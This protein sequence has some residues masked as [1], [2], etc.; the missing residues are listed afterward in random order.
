MSSV[1]LTYSKLITTTVANQ[2]VNLADSGTLGH[3]VQCP[4]SV[5]DLNRFFIW[6]RPAGVQAPVGHFAAHEDTP[7]SSFSYILANTLSKYYTD[8]D[9]VSNGLNFGS[10]ILD[11]NLDPSIRQDGQISANDLIMA[12]VIYKLYG[13]SASPTQ[14]IIYNLQDAYGMLTNSTLISSIET[15]LRTEEAS[16]NA[17][18]V[19]EMFQDL[20]SQD[21]TRFFDAA[22]KQI[23]GLFEVNTATPSTGP[24]N[25]VENDRIELNV[26]FTFSNAVTLA[27]SP[28]AASVATTISAG[29]TFK[30]RLQLLATNT[31][32]AASALVT[33]AAEAKA[34]E[35]LRQA[36]EQQEAA[37][38]AAAAVAAA[39]QAEA[40]AAKQ[41][42]ALQATYTAAIT[43]NAE[44]QKAVLSAQ[45]AVQAAQA[46]LAAATISGNQANIQQQNAA[47]VVAQ[48]VLNN[49]Q[50]IAIQA[51][52]DLQNAANAVA[53]ATATVNATQTA[54]A[55][56]AAQAAAANAKKAKGALDLELASAESLQ[57][58]IAAAIAASDPFTQ[59]LEQEKEAILDPQNLVT[60]M[61]KAN[62]AT[63]TRQAAFNTM[64]QTFAKQTEQLNTYTTLTDTMNSAIAMGS[65]V[66]Q[67]QLVNSMV[68]GASNLVN[69]AMITSGS[70]ASTLVASYSAEINAIQR[71]T[72][73]S[74]NAAS[75]ASVVAI[76]NTNS[77]NKSLT[78][79]TTAYV[80]A[81]TVNANAAAAA[82]DAQT[83][84]NNRVANGA[85]MSE[86]QTRMKALLDANATYAATT[87]TLYGNQA[88][89]TLAT[90]AYQA[91]STIA[92]NAKA[93]IS[94]VAASNLFALS[95][96]K[97]SVS[98][99]SSYQANVMYNA[100]LN[101]LATEVNTGLVKLTQ[102]NSDVAIAKAN[103]SLAQLKINNALARGQSVLELTVLNDI[104]AKANDS[105][106]QALLIQTTAQAA[107]DRKTEN[108]K[109]S[110]VQLL[111][112][113]ATA[114]FNA[115]IT[116]Q[117]IATDSIN[118][119]ST[120]V[121]YATQDPVAFPPI[122]GIP[123]ADVYSTQ[124]GVWQTYLGNFQTLSGS[125]LT[126]FNKDL[127]SASTLMAANPAISTSIGSLS[128]YYIASS[129]S[130]HLAFQV[131][132]LSTFFT[133]FSTVG[134]DAS[135]DLA[136]YSSQYS[137]ASA[138]AAA[139]YSSNLAA[140]LASQT[141]K[142]VSSIGQTI[143]LAAEAQQLAQISTATVNS[144]INEY[145]ASVSTLSMI[146]L[147]YDQASVAATVAGQALSNA[148]ITTSQGRMI[149]YQRR[150]AD[151][152]AA[153]SALANE[154]NGASQTVSSLVMSLGVGSAST[155]T[156]KSPIPDSVPGLQLWLDANDPLGTGSA[157]VGGT[158]ITTWY[159]K[160]PNAYN[161]TASGSPVIQTNSLNLLPGI[162]FV[163]NSAA[164]IYYTARIPPN[165]FSNATT[166]FVVYKNTG[167]N[168]YNALLTRSFVGNNIGTPDINNTNIIIK[169]TSSQYSYNGYS[170][171][172]VYSTTP[173]LFQLTIDQTGDAVYE[174]VTGTAQGVSYQGYGP[175]MPSTADANN[176]SLYIGTRADN[177][178]SF[179]GVFYEILA[180]NTVLSTTDREKIEGYLA[181]KWGLQA[182]LPAGHPYLSAAP[183]SGTPS[184]GPPPPPVFTIR[185]IPGL[186][187][188]LDAKDPLGNGKPLAHGTISSIA[189]KSGNGYD[190]SFTNRTDALDRGVFGYTGPNMASGTYVGSIVPDAT[191]G[192]YIQSRI[193]SGTFDSLTAFI[194]YKTDPN[195]NP[196]T[197]IV[198]RGQLA[199]TT[200]AWWTDPQPINLTG[201]NVNIGSNATTVFQGVYSLISPSTS[202]FN[203]NIDV[204]TF[205]VTAFSDGTSTFSGSAP[206]ET[207]DI[208]NIITI[209]AQPDGGSG[210]VS[211]N[212][213]EAVIFNTVLTDSQRQQMEGY[214]A[215]KWGLQSNLPAGHPY[216]SAAPPSGTPS[217]LQQKPAVPRPTLWLDAKDPLGTGTA[218]ADGTQLTTWADKSGNGYNGSVPSSNDY[219]PC[220][221]F[222]TYDASN[223][224]VNMSNGTLVNSSIPPGTFVN[225][226]NMF[227]VY[228][229]TDY[230]S[231]NAIISRC[232]SLFNT[233]WAN[234]MWVYGNY[235]QAVV[236]IVEVDS[237]GNFLYSGG[238]NTSWFPYNTT[239]NMANIDIDL[240]TKTVTTMG[241]GNYIDTQLQSAPG[242]INDLGDTVTVGGRTDGFAY[243]NI[244]VNEVMIFD[245]DLTDPQRKEVEGYLAWKW[246]LRA[247]L[248]AGHPYS[249]AAPTSGINFGSTPPP[250]PSSSLI[251]NSVL[252]TYSKAATLRQAELAVAQTNALIQQANSA[253]INYSQLNDQL[254]AAN[255]S[256]SS[257]L[258]EISV[259]MAKGANLATIQ[260]LQTKLANIQENTVTLQLDS[261]NLY[262][263]F[264]T[265]STLVSPDPS[266]ISSV[267]SS[268]NAT[269]SATMG[270]R[271]NESAQQL[272]KAQVEDSA[273]A[274]AAAE[275][276]AILTTISTQFS[277]QKQQGLSS[278]QMAPLTSTLTAASLDFA[279]K[280]IL[281]NFANSALAQAQA[282]YSSL[283][284]YPSIYTSFTTVSTNMANSFSSLN[285]GQAAQ[286][287]SLTQAK[288]NALTTHLTNAYMGALNY[289]TLVQA[290]YT[291]YNN[292]LVKY[293][294][295]MA[296]GGAPASTYS[297]LTTAYNKYVDNRQKEILFSAAYLSTMTLATMDP[298][299]M[300]IL[301]TVASNQTKVIEGAKANELYKNLET[302]NTHLFT[303]NNE[304]VSIQSA[305]AVANSDLQIA[306]ANNSPQAVL[307]G[308]YSTLIG[309]ADLLN[310]VQIK[311]NLAQA[312][313][314]VAQNNVAMNPNAQ[315]ILDTATAKYL[316]QANLSQANLL[317]AQYNEAVANE[318]KTY[319]AL[320]TA[321]AA[322]KSAQATFTSV[323]ASGADLATIKAARDAQNT[324]ATAVTQA[325]LLENNAMNALNQALQN[326]NLDQ[327]AQSLIIT[328]R[329]TNENTTAGGAVNAAQA[330][331]NILS[332][333]VA[334]AERTL[335]NANAASVAARSTVQGSI[336]TKTAQEI[337]DLQAA[338]DATAAAASAAQLAFAAAMSNF[339]AEATT[340]SSLTQTFSTTTAALTLN[341]NRNTLL[342]NG[343][344]Y[345]QTFDRY[346]LKRS[347]LPAQVIDGSPF[348]LYSVTV[349]PIDMGVYNPS[350]SYILGNLVYYPNSD[351]AQYMAGIAT[352]PRG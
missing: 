240:V 248:P 162:A 39:D 252:N 1:I 305:Y 133:S 74:S 128:N 186:Q 350:T 54:A 173:S 68:I 249:T 263:T 101:Q 99:S 287:T 136:N 7:G 12:Y 343:F 11:A 302:A 236:S 239:V 264:L 349:N 146:Q 19:N 266:Y 282:N 116:Q 194:V 212:L 190:A 2:A 250:S 113:N 139:A 75:L 107:Y 131:N 219:F 238:V 267:N 149:L 158:T 271:L 328:A 141:I 125:L 46:A 172:S 15:S 112:Q 65:N 202:I 63:K 187:L 227:M 258:D 232:S 247:N 324:A 193:P 293:N 189:D 165:T 53:K 325:G 200:G 109:N 33:A 138:D 179:Q 160:S 95:A 211:G 137:S 134:Y 216:L 297:E 135:A 203:V 279:N 288:N 17:G 341:T 72:M 61:A 177:Y 278:A 243:G 210:S 290:D 261:A 320:Q 315:G 231:Y 120:L 346:V 299:S 335:T 185:S 57:S 98:T 312:A 147:Q 30:I 71:A 118:S 55:Q 352:D 84:L 347:Y 308:K 277:I 201:N 156:V 334:A 106:T 20:L 36:E 301:T 45:A 205:T 152:V 169:N 275:A 51:A 209:F 41:A 6:H 251:P 9:G 154:L 273:A 47:A 213:Y 270:A 142:G 198:C 280:N 344:E 124:L 230:T 23:P 86:V 218:P 44:Q 94:S 50:A 182:D 304:F 148:A 8:I 333:S 69:K 256:T 300:A 21:P 228:K 195:T 122:D 40:T 5:D 82:A 181:W 217:P 255:Q 119:Y 192:S 291:H 307:N 171:T 97:T 164:T 254:Q 314:Q 327:I 197:A 42:A 76:A 246:G 204:N 285:A 59:A 235:Y 245:T 168:G 37:E 167:N 92:V 18:A 319:A 317:V 336:T 102:A 100:K 221:P 331:L 176:D 208:G 83:I 159:D 13:S 58:T 244:S 345:N 132:N 180:Y 161:A 151:S 174:W 25:F 337:V 77:A 108:A 127:T 85:P 89:I 215:W 340:V 272:Q 295:Q 60:I 191:Q 24:W 67:L 196:G 268:S 222:V 351:G 310:G 38:A 166:F 224:S 322:L 111:Q 73:A 48:A 78:T 281:L 93:N 91:A 81:S 90:Q 207:G 114:Y 143:L 79:V 323:I 306:T 56:A 184:P 28:T 14:N 289:S 316:E 339:M 309:I 237:T 292:L 117:Q 286:I 188:W 276:S 150:Y 4:M 342:Y 31:P 155:S 298:S 233:N 52:A 163:G 260:P 332:T 178:T 241:N 26:Q 253:Y 265:L 321:N 62:S 105:L 145:N 284:S 96:Y 144:K 27:A 294:T 234:P 80:Y 313:V 140:S 229:C 183:P 153:L 223:S 329:L 257:I 311:Y 29:T 326:A 35:L 22:G 242:V 348:S 274:T 199:G 262:N 10:A 130:S 338:A 88:K 296:A 283:Q 49:Q 259:A 175:L 64:L 103:L 32:T 34:Q 115:A 66:S 43:R 104:Y 16:P 214:L 170:G 303:L 3:R 269:F 123:S 225:A 318:K 121:S 129:N 220:D 110:Q 330:Q 70:A 226:F 206:W 157:P 87:S 126:Q